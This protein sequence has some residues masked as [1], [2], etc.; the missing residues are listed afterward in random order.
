MSES[1]IGRDDLEQR[2]LELTTEALSFRGGFAS[3]REKLSDYFDSVS[4]FVADKLPSNDQSLD[5]LNQRMYQKLSREGN[6][7]ELRRK[8]VIVPRGL[9][10]D[11][12]TYMESLSK[13][14]DALD[15]LID[16]TLRPF[17]K[18]L[19]VLL[20]DPDTLRSQRESNIVDRVVTHDIEGLRG[21]VGRHFS[22]DQAE[23]RPYGSLVGR[24]ADWA[25]IATT[26]ND[27]VE[28]FAQVPRK[29]VL[30]LVEQ[31]A[32]LL[33]RLIQNMADDPETYEASG[34]SIAELAKVSY[35]MA[36]EVEFYALHAF[37]LEQLQTSI[38][39]AGELAQKHS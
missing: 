34:V 38:E 20:K 31:I 33:D 14:Q 12:L 3:L 37:R 1:T 11:Y 22:K 4:Q 32:S 18:H 27:L 6:Y 9:S 24:Q 26:F 29:E 36:E 19:A 16:D 2:A 17:E 23:R 30:A 39:M 15:E 13:S 28:R 8:A 25:Q 21:E 7:V 35:V 5:L 10:S